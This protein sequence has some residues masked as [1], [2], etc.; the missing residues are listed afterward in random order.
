MG[1]A[2]TLVSVLAGLVVVLGGLVSWGVRRLAKGQWVPESVHLREL[3]RERE[4][5]DERLRASRST[6]TALNLALGHIS[7]LEKG[8]EVTTRVVEAI[9]RPREGDPDAPVAS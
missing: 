4:I 7:A 6:T 1:G 3:A 2:P 5:A 9:P 8:V